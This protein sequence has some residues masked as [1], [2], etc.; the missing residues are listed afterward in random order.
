MTMI[1]LNNIHTSAPIHFI[2]RGINLQ[3]IQNFS[4][5]TKSEQ[6]RMSQAYRIAFLVL[7]LMFCHFRISN[8]CKYWRTCARYPINIILR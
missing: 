5:N 6:F 8:D 3:R 2:L 1:V 4:R 7:H